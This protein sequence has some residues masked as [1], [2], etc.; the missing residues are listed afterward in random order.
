MDKFEKE[1]TEQKQTLEL[2]RLNDDSSGK[3]IS[4]KQE[5]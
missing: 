1:K 2:N 3:E 4:D 5:F